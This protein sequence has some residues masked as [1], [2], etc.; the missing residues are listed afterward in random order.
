MSAKKEAYFINSEG[1]EAGSVK[2]AFKWLFQY[3]GGYIAV[4]ATNN[5]TGVISQV[6]GEQAVKLLV[7]NG[8]LTVSG[9]QIILVTERKP[10]HIGNGLPLVAFY[11]DAK[12]L[13]VLQSVPNV[14]AMLVVPW[15][16]KEIDPWIRTVNAKDFDAPANAVPEELIKNKVVVQALKSL[17]V[18]VNKSTGILHPLDKEKAI[19]TFTILRDAGEEFNPEDVKAF[20]I[21]E[22]GWKATYAQDVANIAQKVL[23]RKKLQRGN[24][25]HFRQEILEI[26]RKEALEGNK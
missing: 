25:A 9:K 14:P 13:D 18:L 12:F 2:K 26:W 22:E 16:R 8:I 24:H 11:P 20:L 21:R 17:S 10:L 19:E 1:P 6:I 7:K 3:D 15:L 5:L 23:E 4:N